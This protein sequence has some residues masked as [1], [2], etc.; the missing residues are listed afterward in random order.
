M[1]VNSGGL[2]PGYPP[3]PP[4]GYTGAPL[5]PRG[6]FPPPLAAAAV[7]AAGHSEVRLPPPPAVPPGVPP[8]YGG[9]APVWA[10]PPVTPATMASTV[11]PPVSVPPVL[12]TLPVPAVP[13]TEPNKLL[14]INGT[15]DGP[16]A[17]PTTEAA[18]AE[19]DK[20]KSD[21]TEHKAP[22]GRTYYY[23]SATRQSVWEKPDDLKTPA[24]LLL[25]KCSWKEYR[26]ESGKTYYHNV[27]TKESHW[28]M[29]KELEEIKAMIAAE[30]AARLA[31]VSRPPLVA[32]IGA[33]AAVSPGIALPPAIPPVAVLPPPGTVP[34]AVHTPPAAIVAVTTA[35]T[36]AAVAS[37]T[38]PP[39]VAT[40]GD[41][42]SS[43]GTGSSALD[44]AMAA[45]LAAINS[46]PTKTPT[47]DTAEEENS[48]STPKD[49]ESGSRTSTPEPKMVFKDKKEAIE[50]FKELLKD[51]DV[52]SNAS[53]E[54][55]VKLIAN[56]PRYPVLKKL[57][58]KKQAFNSY[59][60]QRLKEERELQRQRTKKAREDFEAFLT[61]NERVSSTT[62][63]YR[64]ED[65]FGH[66]DVWKNVSESDRRDIYEDVIFNLAKKEKEEAKIMKKRN[67][68]R[69]AEVLDSMMN[70]QYST[71][72]QEAQQML[73][74]NHEFADDANLL[75]M[76][77][78]DA[79]IVFEEHIRQL[80]KEEEADKEREK[81]RAKRQ[82]RK[83]RDAFV[84][85]L[86]ELHEQGKLTSMSLWVELYP[87]ISADLR[88]SAM[89]GQPGS[90]PLDLFKFY[91][92]DLKSRFH[93]EK[94]IIKEILKEKGFEVQVTT[95]FEDFATVVCE[96]RR[97]ANLDAGNVKLTFNAFLEK[98]E[99]REKERLKEET[100]RLKKLAASFKNLLSSCNVDHTLPWDEI[101]SKMEGLPEFEAV[102][103]ES[104][105]VRIF[106]E[107]QHESEEACSHHH[108]RSKKS[109][110]K[111]NRRRSHSRSRTY[112]QQSDSGPE[113]GQHVSSRS[114]G[115]RQRHGHSR[116]GSSSD[117]GG[118]S[119]SRRAHHK[120]SRKKR[121][122]SASVS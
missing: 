57:N 50:A 13:G 9:Q 55:A 103:L 104:E 71:T 38:P 116:S 34:P 114:R 110:K 60:T 8:V 111:K 32:P 68:K 59:K 101:R 6:P 81:K 91:V 11:V 87:T 28:T 47:S 61:N 49:S 66:M 7:P 48:V 45:T 36:A 19:P 1:A 76:D 22:D 79:L 115:R 88:F 100:R 10:V 51:K 24:E 97:S 52:P 25:S 82:Q 107:Y 84:T 62:K 112:S 21:W 26:S 93:D 75:G 117:T 94:K 121:V 69:L 35:V 40:A 119:S 12:S 106:K 30:E 58:E 105:R 90:T 86:D 89:L 33:A 44:Q 5:A 17:V 20:K 23:N 27:D 92:E 14:Q 29:P 56:D 72:W 120:K 65:M 4:P 122:R 67:M 108:S 118:A 43:S 3:P 96:D 39:A 42:S 74:D 46:T 18:V 85:L 41:A 53:W 31:A 113:E 37:G 98:A 99:A 2:P 16:L 109:K 83:N 70:I 77:K 54:A 95:S 102:G 80:E 63:Y 78:E 64:C 73:L 15:R